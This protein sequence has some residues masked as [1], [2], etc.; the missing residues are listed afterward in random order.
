[1]EC[2]DITMENVYITNKKTPLN[3]KGGEKQNVFFINFIIMSSH[4]KVMALIRN[5]Y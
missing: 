5:F 2:G 1:M 4:A 3:K